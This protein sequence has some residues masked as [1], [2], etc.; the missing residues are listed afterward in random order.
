MTTTCPGT[1]KRAA[2]ICRPKTRTTAAWCVF[3]VPEHRQRPANAPTPCLAPQKFTPHVVEPAL[4][5]NRL[6][7]AV[8]C[9][10]LEH[11]QPSPQQTV[12]AESTQHTAVVHQ[13]ALGAAQL[14]EA[15]GTS[16]PLTRLPAAVAPVAAVLLPLVKK[17]S[18]LP[19]AE[20]LAD[21][22]AQKHHIAVEVDAAGSI[23]ACARFAPLL[24]RTHFPLPVN[25][26]QA[27]AT[28]APMKRGRRCV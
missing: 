21:A 18:L 16:R 8:L 20:A 15:D 2:V 17:D 11:E 7:L 1:L 4:G 24:A 23:G 28:A 27:A 5:V 19:K 26:V 13:P 12:D 6:V 3:F 9:A 25:A 14:R 22:L 10:A